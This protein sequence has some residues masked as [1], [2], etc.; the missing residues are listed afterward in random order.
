MLCS[1]LWTAYK[2][3]TNT[4]IC[5]GRVRLKPDGTRWRTGGEVKGKLANGVS[6]QYSDTTSEHGISSI[7]NVDAHTSAASSRLKWRPRRFKWTRPCSRKTKSGFCAC[8]ITFQTQSTCPHIPLL[9]LIIRPSQLRLANRRCSSDAYRKI[10][11][12]W[13]SELGQEERRKM[14]KTKAAVIFQPARH[15]KNPR[16]ME[17]P[18]QSVGTAFIEVALDTQLTWPKQNSRVWHRTRKAHNR[19]SAC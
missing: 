11:E 16:P 8:A 7:T 15:I 19:P 12:V 3:I 10:S 14:W 18:L 9:T 1:Y 6:S 2:L 13:S 17:E 4:N 5:K